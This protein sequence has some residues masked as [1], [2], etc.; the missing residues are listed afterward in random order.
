MEQPNQ[1]LQ[2]PEFNRPGQV[3]QYQ[4]RVEERPM[5]QPVEAVKTC[6]RKFIDFKGRARRSE[7][8]WFYLFTVIVSWVFNFLGMIHVYA[9]HLGMLVGLALMLPSWAAMTRRLH[10][11]GHSGW[12]VVVQVALLLVACG[13][14]ATVFLPYADELLAASDNIEKANVIMAAVEHAKQANATIPVLMAALAGIGAMIMS[15]IMLIFTVLDSSTRE[16]KYGP[17]PKY[18]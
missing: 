9:S 14:V 5:L 17:S 18:S 1:Q 7:Y 8:W 12:W 13:G 4:P 3:P 6:L 2:P 15:F 11:T 10:D 16:N